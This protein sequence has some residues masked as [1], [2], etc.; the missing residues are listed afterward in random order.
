MG[1]AVTLSTE[2]RFT[3]VVKIGV[4]IVLGIMVERLLY[5]APV[6]WLYGVFVAVLLT[7]MLVL[8]GTKALRPL[9]VLI[10]IAG[11]S[12]LIIDPH[13]ASF[14]LAFL[15]V[16]TVALT[17][18]ANIAKNAWHWLRG[19][20]QFTLMMP[21]ILIVTVFGGSNNL[22]VPNVAASFVSGARQWI[23][24]SVLASM[25]LF[26][27]IIGNPLMF[28]G[29]AS[30][31]DFLIGGGNF[32]LGGLI[33]S[34]ARIG[35]IAL[36]CWP[37][38]FVPDLN[39]A[40]TQPELERE[41]MSLG[42]V[43][44]TL[45]LCSVVFGLQNFLDLTILWGGGAL[46]QDLTLSEYA[47]QGTYPLAIA[48][49]LVG[50]FVIL[51]M[52]AGGKA[53]KNRNARWLT[54]LWLGQTGF[55]AASCLKRMDMYIS[56]YSLTYLRVVAIIAIVL[57]AIGLLWVFL[58]LVW[59]RSNGWL[60]TAST[61]TALAL[62]FI[63]SMTDIGA[64]IAWYN[65]EH[66]RDVGG[67]SVHLDVAYLRDEVGPSAIPALTWF[68]ENVRSNIELNSGK[69]RKDLA[70]YARDV[71]TLDFEQ[72]MTDERAWTLRRHFLAQRIADLE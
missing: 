45:I 44:R 56:A 1:F 14:L 26:L 55:L 71:L 16:V 8:N 59:R 54:F 64:R 23:F 29:A 13:W 38:L 40:E 67:T 35:M 65:V 28:D 2:R 30:V 9:N 63:G 4:A 48:A 43:I 58:R 46:P 41:G 51:L 70:I 42:M 61:L 10:A 52:P 17:T 3:A 69:T 60:F 68:A 6:G 53:E 18:Q 72:T 37:F 32:D 33:M 31:F 39:I 15:G 47:H 19:V 66:S 36:L 49:V 62:L 11:I 57:I 22:A 50:A 24:P 27:F 12:A 21:G 5:N 34:V 7:A 25:F 20:G